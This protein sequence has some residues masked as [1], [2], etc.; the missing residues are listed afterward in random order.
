MLEVIRKFRA[1]TST[2]NQQNQT[3]CALRQNTAAQTVEACQSR[4]G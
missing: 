1:G 2:P 3:I 4:H